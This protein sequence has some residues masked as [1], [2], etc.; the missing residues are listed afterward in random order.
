MLGYVLEKFRIGKLGD[1]VRMFIVVKNYRLF[2]SLLEFYLVVGKNRLEL[3]GVL[4][5]DFRV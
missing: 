4:L 2:R 3:F 1:L 5:M